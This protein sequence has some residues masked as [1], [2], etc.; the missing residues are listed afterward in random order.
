VARG[1]KAILDLVAYFRAE[2]VEG[3]DVA[4]TG[5]EP[6]MFG[7]KPTTIA[8]LVSSHTVNTYLLS[9]HTVA[10]LAE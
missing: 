6:T 4:P 10:E 5:Q 8:L 2:W 1:R 3:N 9:V 7:E